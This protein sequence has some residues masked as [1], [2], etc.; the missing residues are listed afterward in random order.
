MLQETETIKLNYK[1]NLIVVYLPEGEKV[2]SCSL[3][4]AQQE[5]LINNIK[6][7]FIKINE[8]NGGVLILPP[9]TGITLLKLEDIK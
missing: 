2:G 1:G 6:N 4:K 7:H 3:N 5:T 8:E 9:G